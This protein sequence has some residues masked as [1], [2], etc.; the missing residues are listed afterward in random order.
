MEFLRKIVIL[1]LLLSIVACATT[2]VD[3]MENN[4]SK[5]NLA[6]DEKQ[7]WEDANTIERMMGERLSSSN[8]NDL[9]IYLNEV[10]NRIF[11]SQNK[12]KQLHPR[13][14]VI[15]DTAVNAF[16][17]PNGATYI[18]TG[19]LSI[20]ENEAQLAFVMSHELSHYELRHSL[21]QMRTQQNNA[22]R[23]SVL[24]VFLAALAGGVSGTY[25]P[26]ITSSVSSLWSL[27]A[28]SHYSRD[29]EREADRNGLINLIDKNY[30]L[31]EGIQLLTNM[32]KAM[33]LD[34]YQGASNF[35]SHPDIQERIKNY[36]VQISELPAD[37]KRSSNLGVENYY[38]HIFPAIKTNSE[39]NIK[40]GRTE[41]A[42][43]A[44]RSYAKHAEES[45]EYWYLLGEV[46]RLN[47][48]D[49]AA[50]SAYQK[51]A[52]NQPGILAAFREIGHLYR[53]RNQNELAVQYYQKYLDLEP[54]AV[55]APIISMLIKR[56]KGE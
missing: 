30:D 42:R 41:L 28:D 6:E 54:D 3:K 51:A 48:E 14:H 46:Y 44:L 19:I 40:S 29:L 55:E 47:D 20:I 5:K 37:S 43:E 52:S 36:E 26:S 53:K 4:F 33:K 32:S 24:G 15:P 31:S 27:S 13:V 21:R 12:S 45:T 22:K 8:F 17:L 18:T 35:S 56:L 10:A 7:L 49:D 38:T 50:L 16:V 2:H 25:D 11:D 34:G 23:G 1:F 39:L 9:E